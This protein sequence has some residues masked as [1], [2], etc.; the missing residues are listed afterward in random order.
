[1]SRPQPLVSVKIIVLRKLFNLS[2]KIAQSIAVHVLAQ[3]FAHLVILAMESMGA[4]VCFVLL[5]LS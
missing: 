2:L 3:V 1:M 5:E 4:S